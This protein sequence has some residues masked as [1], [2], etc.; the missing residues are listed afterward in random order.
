MNSEMT[1]DKV[2]AILNVMLCY[3]DKAEK[4][5]PHILDELD[6]KLVQF[7]PPIRY[8]G[9]YNKKHVICA[10]PELLFKIADIQVLINNTIKYI[11]GEIKSD[12]SASVLCE[13]IVGELNDLKIIYM[14][15]YNRSPKA[16][17][18]LISE[19]LFTPIERIIVH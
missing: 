16:S 14:H 15:I 10:S 13:E 7:K 6:M 3:I 12:K 2:K 8:I 4:M 9:A 17:C 5:A 18:R 11:S 19:S 1:S